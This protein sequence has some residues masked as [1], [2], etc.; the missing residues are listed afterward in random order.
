MDNLPLVSVCMCTYNRANL[1]RPAIECIL[2]QTYK[3]IELVIVDDG[4][5]DNT[6]EVVKSYTDDR[7]HYT[8]N[9]HDFI[10]S[11]NL[12]FNLSKGKYIMIMDSDDTCDLDKIEKQVNFLESNPDYQ[13]CSTY[14]DMDFYQFSEDV[15]FEQT[16]K[17]LSNP[18]GQKDGKYIYPNISLI[19]EF[20]TFMFKRACLKYFKNK[21]YFYP[22]FKD[23]GED[24]VFTYNLLALGFKIYRMNNVKYNYVKHPGSITIQYKEKY[25]P[26][27]GVSNESMTLKEKINNCTK[28]Y[29]KY[30]S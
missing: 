11:R 9:K 4:S 18:F 7:I 29:Y 27:S 10:D 28:Y 30:N 16:V 25:I 20:S 21:M 26:F 14:I 13:I 5:T 8:K 15:D 19:H 22:E 17:I 2:N 1:M 12:S 23:G 3:N 6:E 24:Q